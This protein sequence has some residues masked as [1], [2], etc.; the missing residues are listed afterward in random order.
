MTWNRRQFLRGSLLA[1]AN[2]AI[3]SACGSQAPAPARP[4]D[5]PSVRP[6]GVPARDVEFSHVILRML[7][8]K[9]SSGSSWGGPSL[10]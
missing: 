8:I 4:T 3:L 9:Q 2:V 10:R 5:A 6:T 1:V 7:G